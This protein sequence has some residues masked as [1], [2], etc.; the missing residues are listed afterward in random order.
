MKSVLDRS[1]ISSTLFVV[2]TFLSMEASGQLATEENDFAMPRPWKKVF[3]GCV[4]SG[5][6]NGAPLLRSGE[7]P[8]AGGE[9]NLNNLGIT[10]LP[11]KSF[12][13]ISNITALYLSKNEIAVLPPDIFKG[14]TGKGREGWRGRERRNGFTSTKA[15]VYLL[16]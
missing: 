14:L 9:L 15:E 11:A 8:T 2:L 4:Y 5:D 10:A 16:Y 7:C 1:V 13:G 12:A 6:L 3:G